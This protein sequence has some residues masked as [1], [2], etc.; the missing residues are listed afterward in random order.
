MEI[1]LQSLLPPD[2]EAR[3]AAL[4]SYDLDA[5]T[6]ND[7]D[8]IVRLAAELCET[9][10]AMITLIDS[11]RQWFKAKV[12]LSI[13]ETSRQIAFCAHTVL[14]DE[15]MIIEDALLDPRFA[16]NPLVIGPPHIRFYAGFPLIRPCGS[17]VGTLAVMDTR[18]RTLSALAWRAL[19][20]LAKQVLKWLELRRNLLEREAVNR[21]LQ[22]TQDALRLEVA[23]T[24][25]ALNRAVIAQE[26]SERL[27]QA[28]WETTTEAVLVV[29][30]DS[31]IHF[32]SPSSL[33]LFQYRPDE[34]VGQPLSVVQPPRLRQAHHE[35]MQR[36]LRTQH[37]MLDWTSTET[38]AIRKDG[39]EIPVEI[40]F[41]ELDLGGQPH[42]V[43]FF[44]DITDRKHADRLLFEEKE[45]AQATLRSIADGVIALDEMG[46][47]TFLNPMAEALTGWSAA[48]A[49]GQHHGHVL[50]VVA[51]DG[52]R[53][54]LDAQVPDV[55][56]RLA[57][58][59]LSLER[60]DGQSLSIEGTMTQLRDRDGRDA[61]AVVAFRDV[62][63]WHQLTA[64]LSYQATHDPLTG[65]VNRSELERR[66]QAAIDEQEQGHSHSLLYL[67]LDQFKVVNDTSGHVAGDA[68]LKEL[69]ELLRSQLGARDTLARLGGD[70]FGVLLKECPPDQALAVADKLRHAVAEFPFAWGEHAFSVG[71][72]IGHV[73]FQAGKTT[74]G[75]VLSKADEAC[76]LAKDL[77]RNRVHSH[78][79]GDAELAR[80][81]GEMEWVGP[82]RKALREDRFVLFEQE[83]V[84]LHDDAGPPHFEILL[85][86]R[87]EH[88]G[89]VP[90]MSFIP[91][92]ER[93]D[94]MPV[95]DR[96]VIAA[97]LTTL[98]ERIRA[99]DTAARCLYAINLSG[100]SVTDV[101]LSQ[102]IEAQ[103]SIHQVPGRCICFE[104]TETAAVG[105]LA[106]A[107]QLMEDMKRL[108]CH[109]SLDDFGSGMS[110]F[111]YLKRLPVDFL[112]IDGVFVR[113]IAVDPID[114][115]MVASIHQIGSLM[116][117]KTIAEFVENE[118]IVGQLRA[119]GVHFGQGYALGKPQP[120][121]P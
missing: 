103:L 3:L 89:L 14:G 66:L 11:T 10:M 25:N 76:Y 104:I 80:R 63:K 96:W 92:A 1:D 28:L 95:I 12:G 70:E 47:I 110:S 33:R 113:D 108:G 16:N 40:A 26:E 99:D 73:C 72:S 50:N 8:E 54:E 18:P 13:D 15:P 117:L 87:D 84:D 58:Q 91:A 44:R 81:H 42:F 36:Y 112:K 37:R 93:Y 7:L 41:S 98:G 53:V 39:A 75:D 68:L 17:A 119:I 65:L 9:P 118:E 32:A 74:L 79:P 83:I 102:F 4:A 22:V 35:G 49:C 19:E 30:R 29:N 60:R 121:Q 69:A 31:V 52:E 34:L 43:G 45:R 88:G 20:V 5:Q 71:V 105:N 24:E 82:L 85:R 86:M 120:F 77:G 101:D 21:E 97:V 64:L 109:F 56:T 6:E 48:E 78:Q 90:P 46:R 67:D 94:L 61:G 23:R 111:A 100:G 51:R 115:A 27:Y 107:T 57:G 2:E 114:R 59:L 55:A 62:S 38:V 116:G 106:R